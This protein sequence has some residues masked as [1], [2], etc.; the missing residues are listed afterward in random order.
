MR[1]C[2][3]AGDGSK[4]YE[5]MLVVGGQDVGFFLNDSKT[6]VFSCNRVLGD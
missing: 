4:D 2:K 3:G 6:K 5:I 1:Y